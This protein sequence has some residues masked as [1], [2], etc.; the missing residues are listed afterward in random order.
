MNTQAFHGLP[1]VLFSVVA[2]SSDSAGAVESRNNCWVSAGEYYGVDP[3]LLFSIAQ[4]ES[5]LDPQAVNINSSSIDIGLMQ[6]NSF[7]FP[8]LNESGISEAQLYEPCTN[9]F[10]GAWILAQSIQRYGHSWQAVG[11]YYAGTATNEKREKMRQT[12]ADRVRR[13][14]FSNIGGLRESGV[15]TF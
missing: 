6:I 10:V 12:Y 3:W 7:W 1:L 2:L 8:L 14:Y 15:I 11:A 9:I 13:R 5:D 4:Q